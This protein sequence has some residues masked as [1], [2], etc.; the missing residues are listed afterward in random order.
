MAPEN[1]GQFELMAMLAVLQ[2]RNH[3]Y[4]LEIQAELKKKTSREYAVGQ[5]YTTLARLQQRKLVE[6]HLGDQQSDRL[7]RP[8]RYFTVTNAGVEAVKDTQQALQKLT[9]GL[10]QALGAEG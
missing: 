2:R 4:G 8:R 1:L 5:I 10:E 9:V 7:G 6:S 3:A